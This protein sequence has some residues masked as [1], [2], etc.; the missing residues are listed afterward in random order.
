MGSELVKWILWGS[1]FYQWKEEMEVNFSRVFLFHLLPLSFQ[2]S[3]AWNGRREWSTF[4]VLPS[5]IRKGQFIPPGKPIQ[6]KINGLQIH[7][8]WTYSFT[9]KHTG[10]G[11]VHQRFP[12][13]C[14]FSGAGWGHLQNHEIPWWFLRIGDLEIIQYWPF[15]V[16]KCIKPRMVDLLL[17]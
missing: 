9:V 17:L 11:C 6:P 1:Y 16:L 10:F 2:T 8:L 3:L 13:P 7:A 12:M 14:S 5:Y 15:R 4:L